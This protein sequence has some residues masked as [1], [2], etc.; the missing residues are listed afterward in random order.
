[1]H[2]KVTTQTTMA[3]LVATSIGMPYSSVSTTTAT[4][5]MPPPTPGI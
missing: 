5:C 2:T 1:M 4:N 3:M